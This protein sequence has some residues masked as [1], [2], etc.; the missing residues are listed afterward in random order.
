MQILNHINK[1]H[2]NDTLLFL[3]SGGY[4]NLD[5]IYQIWEIK[6]LK[7]VCIKEDYSLNKDLLQVQKYK[8]KTK[9]DLSGGK[10]A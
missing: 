10:M 1:L 2:G 4:I 8:S 5:I 6:K 9:S 3:A 7:K